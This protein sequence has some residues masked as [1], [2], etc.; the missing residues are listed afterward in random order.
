M[1]F[2]HHVISLYGEKSNHLLKLTDKDVET[3]TFL[4]LKLTINLLI[5]H[6]RVKRVF[7]VF[8]TLLASR[9]IK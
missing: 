2:I 4:N 3:T 7:T 9:D 5:S 1:W 6:K 8:Q